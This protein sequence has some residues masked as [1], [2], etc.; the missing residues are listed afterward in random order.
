[1]R[2]PVSVRY[3]VASVVL[4]I[5]V[6]AAPSIADAALPRTYQAVRVDSPNPLIDGRFGLSLANVGDVNGDGR[7]DLLTG[8]DKHGA[9]NG[10]GQ[11]VVLN[12]A[13]PAGPPLRV[14]AQPDVDADAVGS[15]RRAGF[16]N[17]VA[18]LADLGSCPGFVGSA[19]ALCTANPIGAPDGIAEHIVSSS[20]IDFSVPGDDLGVVYIFDGAS[21]ALLKRIQMP[22]AD[23]AEQVSGVSTDLNN[24]PRFGRT[25][26]N[27]AG[28]SPCDRN[29]ATAFG[30]PGVSPCGTLP[31]AAVLKGDVDGGGFGDILIGATDYSETKGTA[32]PASDCATQIGTA[33]CTG[34]GRVYVY[35][36]EDIAG[37][38]PGT[39][40]E[41]PSATIKNPDSQADS[42][43]PATPFSNDEAF[44]IL[45]IPLGDAGACSSAAPASPG[46]ACGSTSNTADG[47]PDVVIVANAID[48]FGYSDVG[49]TYELDGFKLST[50]KRTEYP[51]P[52]IDSSWGIAQNGSVTPPIGDV[53]QSTNPDFYVGDIQW[54]GDHQAQGRGLVVNGQ[55]SSNGSFREFPAR[56][57]DPTPQN[58]E[59]F[60]LAAMGLGSVQ[61]DSRGEIAVG[62]I[63]PH[64]P[65]T[66][67][68]VV[69]DVTI[70]D[71][72][73]EAPLQTIFAPDAQ[74]GEAF[75]VS[76]QP[77]GDL[78]N[79]GFLDFAAGAGFYDLVTGTGPCTSPCSNAG[80]V[81]FFLSDNSALPVDPPAE[82]TP[83]A[84]VRAGRALE[85]EA[86]KSAVKKGKTVTISGLI[87]AFANKATCESAQTV[88][89]QRRV[90][91]SLDYVSFAQVTAD[92]NGRFSA[93]TKMKRTQIFRAEL[94]ETDPCLGAVS[95]RERVDVKKK[96]RRKG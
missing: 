95:N 28:L 48:L 73:T 13:N 79:D 35:R 21:G 72:I 22:S 27:P 5:V 12:G 44:G 29:G 70:F 23:R 47:F 60:G 75:G 42:A 78:N 38:N 14:Y 94:Q 26:L 68:K 1:M 41:T 33:N 11:V 10:T 6:G 81:Y 36:G 58:S 67:V 53:G 31:P 65:A 66:N 84:V 15:D 85:I 16:G 56:F 45:L 39:N 90:P 18:A 69:N 24:D 96:K 61:G 63:G 51:E 7:D 52:A 17:A 55:P 80:R 87:D 8:T 37:T 54:S 82:P 4:L 91:G 89:L 49:A 71:P 46:G 93:L 32:H 59:Q 74:G 50:L 83:P 40:L 88:D 9:Q 2:T 86:S 30:G 62:G 57:V 43:T 64:N 3:V 25:V 19:G 34:A 76:M 92:A 20:G 77:M